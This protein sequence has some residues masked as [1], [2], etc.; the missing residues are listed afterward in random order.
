MCVYI[1]HTYVESIFFILIHTYIHHML[2]HTGALADVRFVG[3][4]DDDEHEDIAVA[5]GNAGLF[6][7]FPP[8]FS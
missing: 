6:F 4:A 5:A 8:I 7:S 1:L 3:D 2:Q